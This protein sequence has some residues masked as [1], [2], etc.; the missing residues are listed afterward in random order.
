[1]AEVTI[2]GS[3]KGTKFEK[4][5]QPDL[6]FKKTKRAMHIPPSHDPSFAPFLFLMF[7]V[8]PSGLPNFFFL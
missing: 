8:L 4:F 7:S 5:D 3:W 1:M 6:K 2:Q